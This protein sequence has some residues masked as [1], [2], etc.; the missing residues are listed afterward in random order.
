MAARPPSN[1]IDDGPDVTEFG[2]VALDAAV[3]DWEVSFPVSADELRA[4]FGDKRIAVDASGH[5]MALEKALSDCPQ[6]RFD[7]KQDLLNAMHPIFE[8]ERERLSNSLLSQL[9]ALLPF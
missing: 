3:E 9:R 6:R 5:E 8:T 1:D 4:E 2:I 7:D